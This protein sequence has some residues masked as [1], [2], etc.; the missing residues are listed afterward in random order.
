MLTLH[1][2][3]DWRTLMGRL[4][5]RAQA[6]EQV[7]LQ[8]HDRSRVARGVVEAG[9]GCGGGG[10]VGG[11]AGGG[12]FGV[13]LVRADI[14]LQANEVLAGN[15]GAGGGSGA[16]GGSGGNGADDAGEGGH[17]GRG[18]NGGG[19][20]FGGGGSGGVSYALYSA[21]AN[22]VVG[23]GNL[24]QPGEGG[25]GGEATVHLGAVGTAAGQN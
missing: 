16:N 13:F 24:L 21:D 22:P 4:A 5:A 8:L 11:Q 2:H 6:G 10:G 12:S 9:A 25:P 15:G 17:G 3:P 7:G 18:G 19:G 1:D 20:G 23:P 14:T